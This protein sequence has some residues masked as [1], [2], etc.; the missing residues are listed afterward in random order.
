MLGYL[1]LVGVLLAALTALALNDRQG[2]ASM[3]WVML[4]LLAVAAVA[5]AFRRPPKDD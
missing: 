2:F 3:P 1:T 4:G 5:M